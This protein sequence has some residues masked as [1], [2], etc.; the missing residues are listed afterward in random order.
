MLQTTVAARAMARMLGDCRVD[1]TLVRRASVG[2]RASKFILRCGDGLCGVLGCRA[3]IA[4]WRQS[5][6]AH[7]STSPPTK[8]RIAGH[9]TAHDV[10]STVDV[11]PYLAL[12]ILRFFCEPV[13]VVR[14]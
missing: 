1:H 3:A 2:R 14:T 8:S 11:H 9:R 5:L 7:Q 12:W 13:L 4:E 10:E 6:F